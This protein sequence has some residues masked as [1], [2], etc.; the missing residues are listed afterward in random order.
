MNVSINFKGYDLDCVGTYCP[1]EPCQMYDR[2]GE[3]GTPGEPAEFEIHEI[4]INGIEFFD[5]FDNLNLIN[6]IENVILE[7]ISN[8][9][10]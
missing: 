10:E 7:K 3:P 6:E 9:Y 5:L 4:N 2:N 8:D 1:G